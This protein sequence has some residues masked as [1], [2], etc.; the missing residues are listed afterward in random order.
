MEHC[1]EPITVEDVV[2]VAAMSRRGLHKAFLQHLGCTPGGQLLRVRME[3][4]KR[5]LLE[6]QY[7]VEVIGNMCGFTSPNGFSIAFKH[8]TGLSP[9]EF[10]ESLSASLRP[11]RTAGRERAAEL[12]A[13]RA[14][15]Q[16]GIGRL[17][18]ER[19]IPGTGIPIPSEKP[20]HRHN[21]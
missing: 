18:R 6:S 9:S 11:Q 8:A 10:R 19:H 3:R 13:N 7:K 1:H 4:A 21:C 2:A 12:Y 15:P 16:R 5:L 14:G 17:W 20:S